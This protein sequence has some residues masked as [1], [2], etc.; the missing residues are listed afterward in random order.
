MSERH[1][2]L[3]SPYRLP[4]NHQ[5]LLNEEEMASWLNGFICLWHPALIVGAKEPPKIDSSY[6]HEMPLAGQVFS[7]PSTPALFQPDDWP[8]RVLNAGAI[9]FEAE[10]ERDATLENLKRAIQEAVAGDVEDAKL[11]FGTPEVLTLLALPIEKIRPFLGLGF[12]FLMIESLFDAMEHEHLLA[13]DEFWND[14]QQAIAALLVA[15]DEECQTHLSAAAGRLLAAR[16]VLYPIAVHVLDIL[17]LDAKKL[18]APL[19]A[20]FERGFPLNI[21]ATGQILERLA[22]E[23]P[24]RVQLLKEKLNPDTQPP[25]L[26]IGGGHYREREDA[27][28]PLESQL[29]NFEKGKAVAK[30]TFGVEIDVYGRKRTAFHPQTPMFLNATGFRHALLLNFD[31]AVIP[32][33]RAT[34]VNWSSPDGK[35]IDA[36]TRMPLKTNQA[37]TFFNLVYSLHQ[38]I[39]QDTA[40]TLALLHEGDTD[41]PL[42]ED[43]L[44]LSKLAPVLG[45]WTTFGRYFSDALAGEYAGAASPDDFFADYL[46][47]RINEHRCDPVSAFPRQARQRRK[48]DAAWTLAAIHRAMTPPTDEDLAAVRRLAQ[49]E[50]DLE[51]ERLDGFP[52]NPSPA[53]AELA[54]IEQTFAEKLAGRLQARA[55]D[56]QPGYLL[57]NPCAFPRRIALEL[58]PAAHPFAVEGPIKA[59]QFDADKMRLVVEVPPLGFAWVPRSGKPGSPQPKS[60]LKLAE[61]YT[62]RNEFFEAE[63]DPETGGLRA[64]RDLRTRVARVGQQLVYNPG[65]KMVAR[66]VGV[67]MS[68]TALGEI[69]SEGVI[70]D[71]QNQEIATFRQRFRAWLSRPMLDLRIEIEPKETPTGYPWHSY[72]GARFA[73]R[74][75]LAA[76]MRGVNGLSNQTHH[77]RPLSPDFL[78]IRSGKHNTLLFPGG[79]PFHQ[80]HG[81]RM[82][83]MILIPERETARVFDIGIALDRE[84]QMQTAL[85][86]V[87]P[88][89]IV[90]TT[91]GPPHIGP[92]GWLFHLD[93]PN[94]LLSSL[95][96][97]ETADRAIRRLQARFLE[98]TGYSGTGELRC[99]RD[100]ASS[101]ILDGEGTTSQ[102]MQIAGDAIRIDFS[103]NDLL[104]VQIDFA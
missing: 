18:D 71:T 86:F 87:S 64:I 12:G 40:P 61:E 81:A 101:Y 96:P 29:W 10:T 57:L 48:I 42:Y 60:R 54:K 28:L 62:I 80:R 44:A 43:W 1:L 31:N 16:E 69:V 7:V 47:E 55:A 88:V 17:M 100:P 21:L 91:K 25:I 51:T 82:V 84:I 103:A 83:D 8:Y 65:S 77:T 97:I 104:R 92:S 89:A 102:E 36:F 50:D 74:D 34:V 41:F 46:E 2:Y 39:T 59:A 6:D 68:G 35:S 26:E 67:T 14:I 90:P 98:T 30:T 33:H 52:E 32:S 73:W 11:T 20:A 94:L 78:E 79:L 70:V 23:Q 37:Q 24:D 9:R 76:L 45:Q 58:D 85:G 38:S 27:L 3:L 66:S 13:V 19:P 99:V 72:F 75:D 5:I 15:N 95:K 93:S 63:I 22:T 53:V 49:A 56:N 4:T